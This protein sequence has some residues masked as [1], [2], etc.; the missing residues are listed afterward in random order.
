V[1]SPA[2]DQ[3]IEMIDAER[4]RSCIAQLTSNSTDEIEE[5]MAELERLESV[6]DGIGNRLGSLAHRIRAQMIPAQMDAINSNVG[7]DWRPAVFV[8]RLYRAFAGF[9]SLVLQLRD[10]CGS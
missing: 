7:L 9:K 6:L 1:S 2:S 10:N 4:I 5:L 3:V 8:Y